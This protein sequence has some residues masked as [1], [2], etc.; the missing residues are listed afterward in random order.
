[1]ALAGARTP[2]LSD[3]GRAAPRTRIGLF[4]GHSDSDLLPLPLQRTTFTTTHRASRS[5]SLPLPRSLSDSDS[6]GLGTD[7]FIYLG[8]HA[9][10]IVCHY[11]KYLGLSV[12]VARSLGSLLFNQSGLHWYGY[13]YGHWTLSLLVRSK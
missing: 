12:S 5:L 6:L 7:F 11:C 13:G 4:L 8:Y 9:L 3:S 2:G 1:M 10:S